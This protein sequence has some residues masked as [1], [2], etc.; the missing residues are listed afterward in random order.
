MFVMTSES[1]KLPGV[2]ETEEEEF[3]R[4][5]EFHGK[6]RVEGPVEVDEIS[7]VSGGH[8][9]A[10]WGLP[11]RDKSRSLLLHSFAFAAAMRSSRMGKARDRRKRKR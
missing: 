8:E 2:T 7:F 3:G 9:R 10:I 11:S 1:A 4:H 6:S 5:P